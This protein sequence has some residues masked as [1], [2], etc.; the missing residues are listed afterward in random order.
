MR[1]V[2]LWWRVHDLANVMHVVRYKKKQE[3]K[4]QD[5][6]G[7]KTRAQHSNADLPIHRTSKLP[8]L[9]FYRR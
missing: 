5:R 3:H 2:L 8:V 4:N 6:G 7:E 9:A 1:Q